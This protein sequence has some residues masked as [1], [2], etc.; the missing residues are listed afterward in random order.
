M[1]SCR[2]IL[3]FFGDCPRIENVTSIVC[4]GNLRADYV[5]DDNCAWAM[6]Q[7]LYF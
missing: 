6:C 2:V 3:G 4:G 1:Y 5:N 7:S